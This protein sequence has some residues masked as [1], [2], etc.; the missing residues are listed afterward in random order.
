LALSL[1]LLD[2]L[3]ADKNIF[4]AFSGGLDSTALLFLC[5]QALIAK[6]IK[7][8]KAIHINHNL[9]QNSDKWQ[10]HSESFCK[11]HNINFE[12]FSIKVSKQ[13]SSVESQARQ[14]RYHV[15]ENI[16]NENDQILLAHHRDDVFET[17][18]LRL[19]R[20]TG[21]DGLSGLNERRLFGKGEIIRPFLDIPKS[22]LKDFI[23]SHDLPY[24]EDDTNENNAF[25]R[26]FLRNEIIPA[27]DKR[28]IKL[29]ERVSFT[30][31]T[32]KKKKLSL[33]F[34]LEKNF[35]NEVSSGVIDRES[36]SKTPSFVIEELIRLILRKKNIASPNQRVLSEIMNVF[37]YKKPS[38]ESYVKWS[39]K[40]GEQSGGEVFSEHDEIIFKKN[41]L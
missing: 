15:F 37:F 39:R 20:G 35:Q 34:M 24:V 1:N 8:L 11:T 41:N 5:N 13:R 36:F 2:Q 22:D 12:S 7:N 38:H 40:D 33:D 17:I 25:D 23:H 16:L 26:N 10:H 31:Q 28:W 3:S 6:K 18:L 27:L 32:A 4:V 21:V 29:S 14:A 30:S 9:S 19:F